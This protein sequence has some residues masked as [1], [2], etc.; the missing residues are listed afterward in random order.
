MVLF[1]GSVTTNVSFEK[2]KNE[3]H[4]LTCS[5]QQ[6]EQVAETFQTIVNEVSRTLNDI[7]HSTNTTD[8]KG[9]QVFKADDITMGG[10]A[11]L[12]VNQTIRTTTDVI[13][14]KISNLVLNSDLTAQQQ[15][16]LARSMDLNLNGDKVYNL[17]SGQEHEENKAGDKAVTGSS[18]DGDSPWFGVDVCTDISYKQVENMNTNTVVDYVS[19]VNKDLQSITTSQ[20]DETCFNLVANVANTAMTDANQ[21]IEL[22]KVNM[23]DDAKLVINQTIEFVNKFKTKIQTYYSGVTHQNSVLENT[24]FTESGFE[25]TDKKKVDSET[26]IKTDKSSTS[27]DVIIGSVIGSILAIAVIIIAGY[28]IYRYVKKRNEFKEQLERAK[29]IIELMTG[30]NEDSRKVD[31]NKLNKLINANKELNDE[32]NGL[33][34]KMN[35]NDKTPRESIDTMRTYVSTADTIMNEMNNRKK[36]LETSEQKPKGTSEQ[37]PEEK[38]SKVEEVE[39]VEEVSKEE[40]DEYEIQK[41]EE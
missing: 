6:V 10:N 16:L 32:L 2:E 35:K 33:Q 8:N 3:N 22:G 13:N 12:T 23:Q 28:F 21:T 34:Q 29:E 27:S 26:K 36:I 20:L 15:V 17:T 30:N 5:V 41:V 1:G 40:E 25:F 4:N 38:T 14:S 39:K 7:T 11:E 18:C 37:K 9:D 19:A 24:T 31:L